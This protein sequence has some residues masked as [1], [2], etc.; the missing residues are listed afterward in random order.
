M[1][2]PEHGQQTEGRE[3][4]ASVTEPKELESG[5]S[6]GDADTSGNE[7][8][9]AEG[10]RLIVDWDG[11]DDPENPHNWSGKQKGITIAI[12]STIT[13]ITYVLSSLRPRQ[14]TVNSS[15][16]K[17][18]SIVYICPQHRESHGGFRLR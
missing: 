8:G 6:S 2:I 4:L 5:L 12:V 16:V 9:V 14:Q 3:A 11:P 15:L 7:N 17:A 13:F 10:S 1:G 18:S